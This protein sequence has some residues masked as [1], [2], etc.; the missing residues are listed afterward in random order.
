MEGGKSVSVIRHARDEAV[1]EEKIDY[2]FKDKSLLKR[3]LTH[4]SYANERT[5][6]SVGDYER[7][8]F[9]GD[10][11]LELVSSDYLYHQR[12]D[13][14]E[15]KLTKLRASMVCEPALAKCA[16]DLELEQF[17]L[18][19]KGEENT[20]GR[21]RDSIISDVMEAVIGAMYLDGGIDRAREFIGRFVLEDLKKESLMQDSKTIL[22]EMVQATGF[23]SFEYRMAGEKGPDHDKTFM[24]E[25]VLNGNV[26][27]YGEGRTKKAAEQEAARE[28]IGWL[29]NNKK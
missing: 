23:D 6:G 3:A 13:L 19:G 8:E 17:I 15:G 9:L 29:K 5:S 16:R 7:L 12:E 24:A 2:S 28:A 25:A 11:V 22:Q 26:I 21:N 27:G 14:S 18:L 4:S 20:G 1:L 10:A